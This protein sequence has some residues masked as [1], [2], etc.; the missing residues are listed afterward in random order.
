MTA[1]FLKLARVWHSL[2]PSVIRSLLFVAGPA[3]LP[4]LWAPARQLEYEYALLTAWLLVILPAVIG[5]LLPRSWGRGVLE[6]PGP[7]LVLMPI[8]AMV[9]GWL[10]FVSDQC[11]CGFA[12]FQFWIIVLAVPA[13][14]IG[15]AAFVATR[16]FPSRRWV[17]LMVLFMACLFTAATLW[18]FPQKRAISPVFGFL[19]GPVYDRWIAVDWGVILARTSHGL[20]ALGAIFLWTRGRDSR[21]TVSSLCI[22]FG[23]VIWLGSFLWDS[24]GAGAW[25]LEKSLS[26]VMSDEQVEVRYKR[27]SPKD[28][29]MARE[30]ARDAAF[31]VAEISSILGVIPSHKIKIYAYQ[32]VTSKKLLFG[33]GETDITD[34]WTP[35]VHIELRPSP[36]PTLRHELVHAVASFASWHGIGFHPNMVITEGLA[37]ALAPTD[38][39]LSFDQIAAA[40]IKSGRMGAIES[41]FSPFG[42]WMSSGVRSYAVAGSLLRWILDEYGASALR[43]IYQGDSFEAATHSSLSDALNRWRQMLSQH[44]SAPNS[45]IIERLTRDPGVFADVCPHTAEDLSRNRSE[46]LLTRLRQ[47]RGWDP[48]HLNDW[49]TRVDPHDREAGLE[50]LRSRVAGLMTRAQR[51]AGEI[52][53]WHDTIEKSFVWPPKVTEDLD[54]AF[55]LADFEAV[56]HLAANGLAALDHIGKAFQTKNPGTAIKRQWEARAAVEKVFQGLERNAWRS[57]LAGWAALPAFDE[58]EPWIANYLRARREVNPGPERI[59]IWLS[60]LDASKN[61]PEIYREWL[62][63]CATNLMRL[64]DFS[65]AGNLF[66][67]LI[68]VSNGEAKLLAQQHARRARYLSKRF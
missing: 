39:A 5:A 43:R 57:Y 47:P 44:Q 46:G 56:N 51:D 55:M 32:D 36:H 31:H 7:E 19:H 21:S 29:D 49:R 10:L 53:A 38:D 13:S 9:P 18:F 23:V 59:E 16:R 24:A 52:S 42:F 45:V 6:S 8:F 63:M 50:V 11:Q 3:I 41:L 28:E 2:K 54:T 4:L 37:M 33:G 26:S 40:L 48:E 62:R 25:L 58:T 15:Y 66:D 34:V 68:L 27:Q 30:I 61:S 35:T 67:Q 64:E 17:P 14:W 65:R 20:L 22:I 60:Q 1:V 12:G